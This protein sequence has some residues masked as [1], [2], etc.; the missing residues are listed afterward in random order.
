VFRAMRD[1]TQEALV[2]AYVELR[3]LRNRSRFRQW[4]YGILRNKCLSHLPQVPMA[5]VPFTPG[6]DD[7]HNRFPEVVVGIAATPDEPR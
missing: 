5:G 7:F 3:S 1:L 4:L 6:I 2:S